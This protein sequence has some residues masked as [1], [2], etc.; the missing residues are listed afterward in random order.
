MTQKQ[1]KDVIALNIGK[2]SGASVGPVTSQPGAMPS[3]GM[4]PG[5]VPPPRPGFPGP[6]MMN[7]QNSAQ[8]QQAHSQ[9]PFNKFIQVC[10]S[11]V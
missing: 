1:L 3:Q 11:A 10:I 5:V 6:N 7:V 2:P 9:L 8:P 4:A